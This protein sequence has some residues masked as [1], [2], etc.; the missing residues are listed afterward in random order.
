MHSLIRLLIAALFAATIWVTPSQAER[1]VALV[2][3]NGAYNNVPKLIN[4]PK[5][6]KAIAA[7]LRNLGFDVLT[8]TDLTQAGMTDQLRKFASEAENADVA[9]FY[10][11][12][13]GLSLDGKNYLVPVDVNLKSELDVKLGGPIDV[14]IMLDQTMSMSKVKLVFLDACRD[15]PFVEQI[16]RSARTRSTTVNSGLAEM[17]SSEG[18]LLAF[19]TA[20]GQVAYDGEG[21]NSPFT[22]ALLNNLG[23]ANT[24][25]SVALTKVRAEVADLTR[26][27]QSPWASTNL[28][29]LFYMNGT[30]AIEPAQTVKTDPTSYKVAATETMSGA[31]AMELEFWRSVK[32]SNKP[33]ELNAYLTRYPDGLFSS[34]ARAR[35]AA[36]SDATGRPTSPKEPVIDP[37]TKTADANSRTEEGMSLDR[38][39][40]RNVQRRLKALGF[41]TPV[42]G[43]FGE[44]TRR[45]ITNWQ[46]ARGYPVSGFLN[47]LQFDALKAEG[48]PKVA[49][50]DTDDDDK[51]T[52]SSRRQ[53]RSNGNAGG[54]GP[55][56]IL[57]G[58]MRGGPMRNPFFR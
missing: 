27:K 40:R 46:S 30:A 7:L 26:K 19:A 47:N 54:G 35:I 33:E 53:H 45:A 3:G 39:M 29:G 37:A 51:P 34:I 57:F 38:D 11:A 58:A 16:A 49:E 20:P 41:A 23:G 22:T 5:D 9:L 43:K 13:H 31:G 50:K 55:P 44:E 2:I 42:N 28:T 8:G 56:Q 10:Y 14:N 36:L 24:E 25:I 6:A 32:E 18:T 15:N 52:R 21:S 48:M 1:R 17:K 4:P 12:G